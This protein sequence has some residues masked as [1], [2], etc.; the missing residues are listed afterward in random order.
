MVK[1]DGEGV[2]LV[3]LVHMRRV[4]GEAAIDWES[5]WAALTFGMK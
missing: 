5:F 3:R 2:Y 4:N 1:L